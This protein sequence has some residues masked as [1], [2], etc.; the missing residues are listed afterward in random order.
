MGL[1]FHT[2]RLALLN[3]ES[4]FNRLWIE[5]LDEFDATDDVVVAVDGPDSQT[6]TRV[7]DLLAEDLQTQPDMFRRILHR[8][9]LRPFQ[10]KS[11]HYLS[12]EQLRE[13]DLFLV[14]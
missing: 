8:V 12:V 11:L 3:P 14:R 1:S 9:D 5:Y 6:V 13:I 7:I 10:A 2:S 4:D